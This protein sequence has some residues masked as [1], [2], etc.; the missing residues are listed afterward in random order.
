[1]FLAAIAVV[2]SVFNACQKEPTINGTIKKVEMKAVV[3]AFQP[4]NK[5][6][7][8]NGMFSFESKLAFDVTKQEIGLAD[9][10]AVD[11]WEQTL[12]IKTPASIF[13]AVILAEDSISSFFMS[14]P[15]NEQEYWR[16]EPQKHSNIY[17]EALVQKTIHLLP[18]GEGGEYFDLNLYDKST[19][20]LINLDGFVKIENQIYQYTDNA[21]K[22]IQDGDVAKINL[23]KG[24]NHSF[25]G[26]NMIVNVFK[27][28]RLKNATNE[29]SFNWTQNMDFYP[30]EPNWRGR[31][32]KR[33]RVWVDGH[34]EP[35]GTTYGD[36]CYEYIS[37]TFVLRAEAQ[38][39]NFWGNWVYGNY[40][41]VLTYS[42]EWYYQY[43]INIGVT[44]GCGLYDNNVNYVPSPIINENFGSVNNAFIDLAPNGVWHSSPIFFSR[45]FSV[46]GT[47]T[48]SLGP[49]TNQT[50]TW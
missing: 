16:N 50:Y 24:I 12:A 43:W 14:L 46:H 34:S 4:S 20:G 3:K 29:T 48:W 44:Y 39:R 41:P 36:H 7:V 2:L 19:A 31:D 37:C 22:I 25:E 18:D 49:K 33:V 38:V 1:M 21:I 23:I 32:Q 27:D 8:E 45:P 10:K 30:F 13:N 26:N 11:L 28:N 5:V 6:V 40:W 17:L 35:Y 15:E 9:R 42:A 47:I